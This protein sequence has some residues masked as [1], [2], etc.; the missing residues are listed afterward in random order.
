L[1]PNPSAPASRIV[2]ITCAQTLR[3]LFGAGG[4]SASGNGPRR[5]KRS[6]T[7]G[8]RRLSGWAENGE[9]RFL[10]GVLKFSS[11]VLSL[12]AILSSRDHRTLSLNE[13][14]QCALAAQA[15]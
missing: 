8:Q 12:F 15:L 10:P 7:D 4:A 3:D 2:S 1:R 14:A 9:A 13:R 5:S 11:F 6:G